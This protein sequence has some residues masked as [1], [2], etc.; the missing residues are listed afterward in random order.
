MGGV[1]ADDVVVLIDCD[2]RIL[3]HLRCWLRRTFAGK[4][5]PFAFQRRSEVAFL[6]DRIRVFV[7]GFPSS[8]A[9]GYEDP[10]EDKTSNCA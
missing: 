5:G 8:K 9:E 4:F 6:A 3:R 1:H 10:H 2:R 7:A